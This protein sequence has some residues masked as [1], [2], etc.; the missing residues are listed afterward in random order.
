MGL[1]CGYGDGS[2]RI[3]WGRSGRS[4]CARI[5]K[6]SKR[7]GLV[8]RNCILADFEQYNRLRVNKAGN[9]I[10]LPTKAKRK[11]APLGAKYKYFACESV[12]D[13]G[14]RVFAKLNQ[15]ADEV[16]F[17]LGEDDFDELPKNTGNFNSKCKSV[18][19]LGSLEIYKTPGSPHFS[20]CRRY[21][22][23]FIVLN[24]GPSIGDSCLDI[25]DSDGNKLASMGAYYPAGA[26][27]YRAY[28]CWGCSSSSF[29]GATLA[30]KARKNTGKSTVY[31]QNGTQCIR[32]PDPSRCYHSSSC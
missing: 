29:N 4:L 25:L 31:I 17:E 28:A 22:F 23:G 6:V 15:N 12:D 5:Q 11:A 3:D 1:V 2:L 18:R 26:Y 21:S 10:S 30:S 19:E 9:R 16:Q 32:V 14:D 8:L 24:G 20:D 7:R 27:K 13:T